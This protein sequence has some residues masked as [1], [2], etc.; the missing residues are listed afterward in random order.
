[1]AAAQHLRAFVLA[2]LDVLQVGLHLR[3]VDRRTHVDALVETVADLQLLR[4]RHELIDELLVHA[5]LHD[6][7]AGRGAALSGRA[8]RSP[9][10]AFQRE[11]EIG[12]VEHDHRIL[13]AEFQRAVLEA[14]R[15]F[16]SDDAAHGCRSRERNRAH[17]RML[18]H[19][20]ADFAAEAGDDV[21]HARGNAAIGQRL[22]EVQRRERRVLRRLDHRGVAGDQGREELPR[23][24]RHGEVPRR[25]HG[26][27]A[28]RLAHG[29]GEFVGQL[30]GHGRPK[31]TA[32]FAGGVVA[33]VDG[34][35]HV[36]ARLFDD[37][38]HLARHLLRVF[39]L[40]RDQDFG[41]LYSISAR[42]GAGTRRHFL[43]ACLAASM[44]VSTS[45]LSDFWKMPTTSRVSAGLRFSK[46][47]PVLALHPLAVD[48]VLIS[49]GLGAGVNAGRFL[50][51]R[52]HK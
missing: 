34:L 43:Y 39:F 8:E 20:R 44:A 15:R 37:L 38:A 51:H 36:A 12:V 42:R 31:Q 48:E 35:L 10:R 21:D 41:A 7:A 27:D 2:D 14:L 6:D 24:N 23:R 19:R 16:L 18:D 11:I 13:A 26:A 29:H 45:R 52:R 40:A 47:C 9:Q 28:Q 5:L 17:I 1:M 49:L 4:A 33:A 50:F 22:H 30:R 25:D 46:V 32:A 3:R